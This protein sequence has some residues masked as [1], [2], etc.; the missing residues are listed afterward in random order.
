MGCPTNQNK[1]TNMLT[2]SQGIMR[3]GPVLGHDTEPTEIPVLIG[4]PERIAALNS[5][6]AVDEIAAGMVGVTVAG[7]EKTPVPYK[8]LSLGCIDCTSPDEGI[9]NIT[10]DTKTITVTPDIGKTLAEPYHTNCTVSMSG[11]NITLS[12]ITGNVVMIAQA[13]TGL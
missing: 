11:N 1:M 2:D 6:I 13:H 3:K 8:T 7:T 10:G 5:K 9:S 12:S 4:K